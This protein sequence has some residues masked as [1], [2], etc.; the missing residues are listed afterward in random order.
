MSTRRSLGA[1]AAREG[2]GWADVEVSGVSA[3]ANVTD[4][5]AAAPNAAAQTNG[6]KSLG[7]ACLALTGIHAPRDRCTPPRSVSAIPGNLYTV[8]QGIIEEARAPS[9]REKASPRAGGRFSQQ[10]IAALDDGTSFF[11]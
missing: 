5:A 8:T 6:P 11:G 3:R 7:E 4:A 1:G 10:I 9:M 2:G